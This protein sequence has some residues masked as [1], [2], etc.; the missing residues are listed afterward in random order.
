MG[1]VFE[2]QFMRDGATLFNPI[3][4]QR[5]QRLETLQEHL[6]RAQAIT[7]DLM[8]CAIAQ[9]CLRFQAQHPN[10][11][12]RVVRLIASGAWVDAT[13]AL[14]ELELPQWKLRRLIYE[15][16]KWHCSFSKRLRVPAELDEMA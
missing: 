5:E 10:A 12:A 9:G 16:G 8:A 14:L 15:D 6:R 1:R 7:S 4:E 2:R 3:Q 11:K 13:L